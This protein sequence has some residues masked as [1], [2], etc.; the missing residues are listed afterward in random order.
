MNVAEFIAQ[1]IEETDSETSI[2][3]RVAEIAEGIDSEISILVAQCNAITVPFCV[4]RIGLLGRWSEMPI[5]SGKTF[6]QE[7]IVLEHKIP[8]GLLGFGEQ[9]RVLA[10][11]WDG[12]PNE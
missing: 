1:V 11:R 7:R 12:D 10:V 6:R 4:T 3:E 9:S 8:G 5:R 2:P